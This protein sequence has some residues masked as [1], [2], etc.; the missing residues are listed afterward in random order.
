MTSLWWQSY[1][2]TRH[3]S[4][5]ICCLFFPSES[6]SRIK[7]GSK[8]PSDIRGLMR[9]SRMGHHEWMAQ[10]G[11]SAVRIPAPNTC[12]NQTPDIGH[13]ACTGIE[14][15]ASP[16]LLAHIS[17]LSLSLS[18]SLSRSLFFVYALLRRKYAKRR[19]CLVSQ[20]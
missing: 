18:L 16:L 4:L 20:V 9:T 8:Q 1:L 17:P 13:P 15:S 19:K 10:T 3:E 2:C 6:E 12:A 5:W 14:H 7:T 11:R